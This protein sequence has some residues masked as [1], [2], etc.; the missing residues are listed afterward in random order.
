ML[1]GHG[2]R[3]RE[4]CRK[5]RHGRCGRCV[6]NLCGTPN[7]WGLLGPFYRCCCRCRQ[8]PSLINC[9]TIDWFSD[10]PDDA[11]LSVSKKF[12]ANSNLGSEAVT[13]A[14]AQTCLHIHRCVQTSALL[15][16]PSCLFACAST[17]TLSAHLANSVVNISMC[18]CPTASTP[19]A[20]CR[21]LCVHTSI[22]QV[23][24]GGQH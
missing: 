4:L 23:C 5:V 11:L 22:C 8:F 14:I 10:W 15:A 24:G 18:D 12:L 17:L 1:S 21:C 9:C 16:L 19:N 6:R 13:D 2:E 20:L 3:Q 7:T